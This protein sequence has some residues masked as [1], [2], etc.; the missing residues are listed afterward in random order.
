MKEVREY[1][2]KNYGYVNLAE[3]TDVFI[4]KY[5]DQSW[6]VNLSFER[7]MDCLY[8]YLMEN[9]DI[10]KR[11]LDEMNEKKL[12]C[13]HH[14]LRY[15]LFITEVL[16]QF[17]TTLKTFRFKEFIE[18]YGI[19]KIDFLKIDC[20]GGEYDILTEENFDWIYNNV[21]HIAVEVHRRHADSGNRDMIKFR[22]EFL[23]K[24]EDEGRLKYQNENHRKGMWNDELILASDWWNLPSEFMAYFIKK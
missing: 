17:V 19:E 22:N 11:I 13:G 23:K 3:L 24:Y 20:E 1:F 8:D 16:I 2:E 15:I 12:L 14:F 7:K 6:I 18:H 5:L 4:Q 21:G 10:K 9:P